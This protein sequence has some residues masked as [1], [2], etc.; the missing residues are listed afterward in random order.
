MIGS[1]R[2]PG[3]PGASAREPRVART[4]PP[5]RAGSGP[6][7]RRAPIARSNSGR[8]PVAL[9]DSSGRHLTDGYVSLG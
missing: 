8:L 5:L 6:G 1:P 4:Q 3:Q 2:R 9:N 7:L